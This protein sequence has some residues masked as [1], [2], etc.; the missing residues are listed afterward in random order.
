[1]DAALQDAI[2]RGKG[3]K[4]EWAG[5]SKDRGSCGECRSHGGC[6]EQ[7]PVCEV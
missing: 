7:H 6:A 4:S 2:K 1:M 3:L 5:L